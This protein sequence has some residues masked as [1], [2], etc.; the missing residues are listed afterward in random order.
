MN[1]NTNDSFRGRDN[2]YVI[3]NVNIT[4]EQQIDEIESNVT[5]VD[6][7][8]S[9]SKD[10]NDYHLISPKKSLSSSTTTTMRTITDT[11][12]LIINQYGDDKCI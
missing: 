2:G 9:D 6:D 12:E 4:I 11:S 10:V 5:I 1:H 8:N 7:L 3:G